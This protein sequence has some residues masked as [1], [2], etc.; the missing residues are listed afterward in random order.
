M[1]ED[2]LNDVE[3]LDARD[4]PQRPAASRTGLYLDP[5]DPFQALRPGHCGAAF[6]WRPL[7]WVCTPAITASLTPLDRRHLRAVPAVGREDP[8]EARQVDTLFRNQ[9]CQAGNEVQ[10]VLVEKVHMPVVI[11]SWVSLFEFTL[12]QA[13][14]VE[15]A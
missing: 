5:E 6:G 13:S 14:R 10:W 8:V 11:N 2:L 4:D 12:M 7:L 9:G 3:I 1:G 15:L